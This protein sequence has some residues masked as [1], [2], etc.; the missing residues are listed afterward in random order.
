MASAATTDSGIIPYFSYAYENIE[1]HE[2]RL[3]LFAIGFLIALIEWKFWILYGIA[4]FFFPMLLLVI[5]II[6]DFE[7]YN[8]FPFAI[9]IMLGLG[10]SGVVGSFVGMGANRIAYW[11]RRGLFARKTPRESGA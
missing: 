9:I 1:W 3:Y 4:T 6:I 10:I 7:H 2:T 8:L 11:I 5:Q